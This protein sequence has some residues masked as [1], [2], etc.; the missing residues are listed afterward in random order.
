VLIALLAVCGVDLGVIVVL[1]AVVLERKR[2]V[3][4]QRGAFNGAIRIIDADVPGLKTKWERGARIEVPASDGGREQWHNGAVASSSQRAEYRD[5]LDE[6][7]ASA[8]QGF[9]PTTGTALTARQ[10]RRLLRAGP[11]PPAF[12]QQAPAR[13]GVP[14]PTGADGPRNLAPEVLHHDPSAI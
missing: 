13:R 6:R 12:R 3:S 7:G 1:L 9:L 14:L 4:H 2:W 8:D 10:P 11:A 5:Q